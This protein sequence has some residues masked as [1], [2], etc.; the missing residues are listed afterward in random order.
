ML[1]AKDNM[2]M[3]KDKFYIPAEAPDYLQDEKKA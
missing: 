1:L 2:T 3:V